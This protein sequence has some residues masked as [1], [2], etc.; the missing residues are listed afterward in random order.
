VQG[1]FIGTDATGTKLLR[2]GGWGVY[3]DGTANCLIGG[4]T[5]AAGTAPGNLIADNGQSG[6]QANSAALLIVRGNIITA[7]QL[8]GV[9]FSSGGL[10]TV[11]S[12]S[13][14]A[15]GGLGI[16]LTSGANNSQASP[17][18]VQVTQSGGNVSL[19]GSFSGFSNTL[20]RLEFFNNASCDGSGFGEGQVFLGSQ[21]NFTDSTGHASFSTPD[22]TNP[23]YANF[24]A[25]VTDDIGN[26]SAFS[27]CKSVSGPCTI[28]CP[29]NVVVST[30][31]NQCGANVT[32]VPTTSGNC[33]A[34]NS[35]PPSGSFFPKGTN[36]VTCTSANGTNC[37][38]TI[39]VLDTIA[40]SIICPANIVTNIPQDQTNAV[41]N[42][43]AP[44]VTDNCGVASTIVLPPSGSLFRL[45][46][47]AVTCTATD[48]SGNTN[49]CTFTV[50][51]ALSNLPP[52][53]QCRNVTTSANASC[54]AD[55]LATAVD[56]GS[57]DPDGTIVSLTLTPPSPYP[58]GTNTVTFTVLDN[59]GASNS[60]AATIVVRDTTPPSITCPANIVTNLPAGQTSL[61]L[62]YTPV[63][64]DNC[65]G[66]TNFSIPAS[67]STFGLGTSTV[68][69]RAIDAA[70]NS[71]SCTFTVTI[72][73]TY[74]WSGGGADGF[75]NNRTNWVSN[76]VPVNGASLVFPT[77]AAR[78][79]NT[80]DIG[81]RTFDNVRFD[82]NGYTLN[83]NTITVNSSIVASNHSGFNT[84]NLGVSFPG[85]QTIANYGTNFG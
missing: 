74:T 6:V 37:S 62:N 29:S 58:I 20:Y 71:N 22:F 9:N 36:L 19:A 15:N 32:F 65:G 17:V 8:D 55:V 63:V 61:A 59:L 51:V 78:L 24:T 33:G 67:G 64:T 57:F 72:T 11:S 13:I 47:T 44:T 68:T 2:N 27:A 23:P 30:A 54:Q 38:F 75:W 46:T 85:A 66:G 60:C 3:V 28:T 53:A 83:G 77:G 79:N 76:A 31:P 10:N 21:Y 5:A 42:F 16:R 34:V 26:S 40:P 52:V 48:T 4:T 25:T 14:F 35:S 45:G 56:N 39:V 50:T 18:I 81:G 7:N 84:V 43:S 49:S 12:N 41:V 73:S 80:N 82:T 70:G 1:N 69:C